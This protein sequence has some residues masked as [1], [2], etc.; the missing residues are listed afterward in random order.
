MHL[1]ERGKVQTE[2]EKDWYEKAFG[3]KRN[4]MRFTIV[5]KSLNDMVKKGR[6]EFHAKV[7]Y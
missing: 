5:Y 3:R 4:M 2:D 6:Y 7:K 1:K